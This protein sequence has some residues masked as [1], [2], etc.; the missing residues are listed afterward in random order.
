MGVNTGLMGVNFK[1][2]PTSSSNISICS[3][4]HTES[5]KNTWNVIYFTCYYL[6]MTKHVISYAPKWGKCGT[7]AGRISKVSQ[8]H[9]VAYQITRI[10]ALNQKINTQN[11][12][13]FTCYY[14]YMMEH[15]PCYT[16]KWGKYGINR[17]GGRGGGW[18]SMCRNII[19]Y[20][21]KLLLLLH[22]VTQK[23]QNVIYFTCYYLYMIK[24]V[25]RLTHF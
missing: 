23:R 21:I 13:C 15:V 20:H 24:H 16:L 17:A 3:S 25:P 19:M 22:W 12:F 10:V 18:I 5:E 8:H 11:V 9:Q 1:R 2:V 14:V 7:S 6:Y 4:S